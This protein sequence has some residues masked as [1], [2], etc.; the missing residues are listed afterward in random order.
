MSPARGGGGALRTRSHIARR[1]WLESGALGRTRP[2]LLELH[3]TL[4]GVGA[5]VNLFIDCL[6][7]DV[8]NG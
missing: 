3:R 6:K 2:G 8:L 5:Y 4:S 7:A 1:G